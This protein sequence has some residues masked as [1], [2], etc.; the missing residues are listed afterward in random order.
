LQLAHDGIIIYV[1][2]APQT[3]L[4]QEKLLHVPRFWQSAFVFASVLVLGESYW[5][6]DDRKLV[7]AEGKKLKSSGIGRAKTL[8]LFAG[9]THKTKPSG[10]GRLAR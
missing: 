6:M 4:D 5:Y 9:K 7:P 10:I 3:D 1:K 2:I 8:T